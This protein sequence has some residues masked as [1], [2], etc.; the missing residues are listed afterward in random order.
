ME[1]GATSYTPRVVAAQ[2]RATSNDRARQ[3]RLGFPPASDVNEERH[4]REHQ[5]PQK[6]GFGSDSVK[7]PNLA[8]N[9]IKRN[10]RQAED[11]VPTLRE[12]EERVR[13]RLAKDERN[14][15]EQDNRAE[16]RRLDL[17]ASQRAAVD[18]TRTFLASVNKAAGEALV[19]TGQAEPA[20]TNRLDIRIGDT[21]VPFDK[22]DARQPLDLFA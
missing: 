15:V 8:A 21:Q 11:L 18:G 22:P 5:E 10:V 1:I 16:Q 20:R 14:L 13:E 7:I 9:T 6:V 4:Q 12:S 3:Q 17:S 19:R 2:P